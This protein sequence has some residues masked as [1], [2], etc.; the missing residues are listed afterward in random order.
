MLVFQF[1]RRGWLAIGLISL[2]I[3]LLGSQG[4][5]DSPAASDGMT[6]KDPP[7]PPPGTPSSDDV[8]GHSR[9]GL[10][11]KSSRPRRGR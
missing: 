11:S 8:V 7:P 5:C 9:K 2:S 3:V 1:P 4:G 6:V 10:K